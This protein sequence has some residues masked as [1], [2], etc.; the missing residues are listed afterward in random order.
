MKIKKRIKKSQIDWSKY[1]IFIKF[2][3]FN[4]MS[5]MREKDFENVSIENTK[6]S[7]TIN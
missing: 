3:I 4:L 5:E 7:K 6:A 2:L 1:T